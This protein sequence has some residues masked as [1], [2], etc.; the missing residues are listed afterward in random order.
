M[1]KLKLIWLDDDPNRESFAEGLRVYTYADCKGKK[2]S[3]KAKFEDLS[4]KDPLEVINGI[5]FNTYDLVVVDHVLSHTTQTNRRG[6]TLATIISE[7]APNIPIFGITADDNLRSINST[8]IHAY[9]ELFLDAHFGDKFSTITSAAICF[10]K[11]K[12]SLLSNQT[13]LIKLF[14]PH[15]SERE[16]LH[17]ICP[18]IENGIKPSIHDLYRFKKDLFSNPGPLLDANWVANLMGVKADSFKRFEH[19]FDKA[20][21]SGVFCTPDNKRW[22]RGGVKELIFK[23]APEASSSLPWEAG[24][25]IK[26]VRPSDY[27]ECKACNK[28]HPEILGYSDSGKNSKLVPLHIRCSKE[29]PDF[30]KRIYF[31][32]I[33]VIK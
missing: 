20:K 9:D 7:S 27:S 21:Y 28:S 30:P 17:N 19:L 10:K 11:T 25:S 6:S 8:A 2:H 24:H 18:R 13:T 4:Q 26:N 23:N 16:I 29:H 12:Q 1:S 22:W 5:K 14:A 32:E 15:E 33:R 31:E 3:L